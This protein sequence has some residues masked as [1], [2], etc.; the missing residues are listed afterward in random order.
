MILDAIA[1]YDTMGWD[2]DDLLITTRVLDEQV[3]LP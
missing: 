3:R 1:E 2:A